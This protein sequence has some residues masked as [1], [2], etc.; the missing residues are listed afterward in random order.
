MEQRS[1]QSY[2]LILS[3]T[4][5][6]FITGIAL[7]VIFKVTQPMI[8]FHRME[9]I[10]KAIFRV[11]PGT[12]TYKTL[13]VTPSGLETLP[14]SR[15]NDQEAERIYLGMN[16]AGETVGF[17]VPAQGSGFM[18]TI[19]LMYGY[20]STSHKIVGLEVLEHR[21]TPGL[22]DKIGKD[23]DFA[24]NFKNL[25]VDPKI[26]LVK[27]G[28]KTQENQAD[29]ISGATISSDA[30]IK[31]LNNAQIRYSKLIHNYQE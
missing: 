23:L 31:I 19:S 24:R 20:Q 29:A 18:D 12:M 5:A 4:I 17:A 26:M 13:L 7:S 1:P 3:L 22:G 8:Q 10:K 14:D 16:E 9:A 21:E 28:K 11:L 27:K 30:V 15:K 6:G 2:Q 25:L